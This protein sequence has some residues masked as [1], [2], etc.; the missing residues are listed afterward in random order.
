MLPFAHFHTAKQKQKEILTLV[1]LEEGQHLAVFSSIYS[2][3]VQEKE[4]RD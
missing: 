1:P 4:K 3:G 2:G